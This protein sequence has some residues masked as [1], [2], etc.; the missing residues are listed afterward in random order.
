MKFPQTPGVYWFLNKKKE[1][2]Y[3]G[4]AKNLNNRLKSYTLI[5]QS[6]PKT[7]QMLAERTKIKFQQSDSEFEAILLEAEL[8]K[9][10]QPKYNILLKDDKSKLYVSITKETFPK[11]LVTRKSGD[12]GPFS[13]SK[14][15]YFILKT[16]RRIF[17]YCNAKPGK[18][19]FYYH[20]HLCPGAC[21]GKISASDYQQIIN[22]LKLLLGGKKR[23]LL[24]QLKEKLK[25]A[26]RTQD[27]ETAADYR[28]Q[29]Q[30]INNLSSAPITEKLDLPI[31]SS[32]KT[33]ERIIYLRRLLKRIFP[34]PPAYPLTR[35]EAYDVSNLLGKNPTASMVVFINGQPRPDQ[36]RYFKICSLNTPNDLKMLQEVLTR[37]QRHLEWGIPNLILID[38]G[39][40]QLKAVKKILTWNIPVIG[41]AKRPDRLISLQVLSLQVKSDNPGF[42]LLQYLRNESHRFAKKLHLKLRAVLP[43]K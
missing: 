42:Q 6:S 20:L 12:F 34:L 17:P 2:I 11:V 32:D 8:I 25:T 22:H 36:Y 14:Q 9:T 16:L 33:N 27:Y 24:T 5:N 23:L 39:K 3:V 28:N 19:C 10:Y 38:G 15:L 18:A 31:L 30:A 7:R 41:L 1:V 37:R 43:L 26:A 4:K 13:S 40:N 35:I 29:I 21:C